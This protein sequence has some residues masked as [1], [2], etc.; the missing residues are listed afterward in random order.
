MKRRLMGTL[1]RPVGC[2]HS[3]APDRRRSEDA[4]SSNHPTVFLVDVDNTLLDNDAI[5][6][7]MK[8]HLEPLA[9]PPAR[10]IGAS[11]TTCSMISAIATISGPSSAIVANTLAR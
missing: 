10:A 5:Q 4:V 7:D 8:D 6:Q 1:W 3:L 11:W 2:P 9:S